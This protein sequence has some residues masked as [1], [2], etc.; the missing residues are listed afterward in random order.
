MGLHV[1]IFT[2]HIIS[3]ILDNAVEPLLT[4]YLKCSS[5]SSCLFKDTSQEV[6]SAIVGQLIDQKW[7][8]VTQPL[9][10]FL[11]V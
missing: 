2:Y 7:W 1:L 5:L 3:V 6:Q 9:I 8:R 4:L 11:R 10:Y